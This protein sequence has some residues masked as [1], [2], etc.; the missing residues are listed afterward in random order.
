MAELIAGSP[1]WWV[2]RLE[3]ELDGRRDGLELWERYYDGRHPL[4]F[5]T[6][7]HGAKMHDEF[8][9]LLE[10]SRSN[11]CRLVVDAVEERL[12]VEGI[13]LSARSD[14]QTDQASWEIWQANAMDTE[15]AAAI[16]DALVKGISYLS[17]WQGE[18]P[19]TIRPSLWKTRARQS[20]P[21]RRERTT[22]KR[23]A[24]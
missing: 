4:P 19:T 18:R 21:T 24:G 14:A 1:E 2:A 12:E 10:E 16:L 9:R 13:R 8:R 7:A 23:D 20:W 3:K 22:A 6:K 11:F 17:V 15:S 5:I